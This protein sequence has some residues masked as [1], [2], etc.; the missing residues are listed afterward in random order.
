EGCIE[1]GIFDGE[2]Y[3]NLLVYGLKI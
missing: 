3:I 2:K 1:D